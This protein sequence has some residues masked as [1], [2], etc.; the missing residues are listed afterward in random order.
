MTL[1]RVNPT[2]AG[3][4]ARLRAR[5][6]RRA[7]PRSF[8]A[9]QTALD[10]T[11]AIVGDGVVAA[12]R[13][14]ADATCSPRCA[15]AG[16]RPEQLASLTI[17]I[18]DI[19]DYRAHARGDRCGLAAAG[20]HATTRR[21]PASA[22]AG[23][24]TTT[25][26]SRCRASPSSEPASAPRRRRAPSRR[27]GAPDRP[28]RV[29]QLE[30]RLG[31]ARRRSSRAGST[32]E[33]QARV[34]SRA[35]GARR[36][37][38]GRSRRTP[39]ARRYVCAGAASAA[40]TGACRP[41]NSSYRL[42]Q[43]RRGPTTRAPASRASA[44]PRW[45]PRKRSTY[46]GRARAARARPVASSVS[47]RRRDP[48]ARPTR[49]RSRARPAGSAAGAACSRSRLGHGEHGLHPAVGDAARRALEDAPVALVEDRRA[50][51]S[52]SA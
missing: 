50:P 39:A 40:S 27:T 25:R 33:R 42:L 16:G 7:A 49:C 44:K 9:G 17:Y 4:A 24:G 46:A 41:R 30:E 37:A 5:G 45:S 36:S 34:E 32:S 35:A 13:A 51:R 20:R 3:A 12:V 52:E 6:R 28:S 14:G 48:H 29:L 2:R 23:S 8:L 38:P 1:E 21:W 22:F 47:V 26:S 11:G 15:A 10:A 43:P 19:D 31:R 18:V